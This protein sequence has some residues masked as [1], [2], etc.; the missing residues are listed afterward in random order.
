MYQFN[1]LLLSIEK[2]SSEIRTKKKKIVNAE[3]QNHI[4]EGFQQHVQK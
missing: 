3:N 1:A 2:K 4:H